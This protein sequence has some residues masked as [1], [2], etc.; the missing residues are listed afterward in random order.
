MVG[1][2]TGA[3]AGRPTARTTSQTR[4][5]G[6]LSMSFMGTSGNKR[7]DFRPPTGER[8]AFEGVVDLEHDPPPLSTVANVQ[9][10]H[11]RGA[12]VHPEADAIRGPQVVHIQ[13]AR[14]RGHFAGV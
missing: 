11:R 1:R 3:H 2:I 8:R 13:I 6:S 12:V 7:N 14:H 9:P 5:P 4:T 10:P